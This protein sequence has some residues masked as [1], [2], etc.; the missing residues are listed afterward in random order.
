MWN[1]CTRVSESD[2]TVVRTREQGYTF[3]LREMAESKGAD[4]SPIVLSEANIFMPYPEGDVIQN[5]YFNQ[6]PQEY[7]FGE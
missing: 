6:P 1:D 4:Y 5:P 7:N 3:D 2:N